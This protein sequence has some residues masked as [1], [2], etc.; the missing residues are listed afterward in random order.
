LIKDGIDQGHGGLKEG[1]FQNT[2]KAF[3][4]VALKKRSDITLVFRVQSQS[5]S[6]VQSL[7]IITSNGPGIFPRPPHP[8]I[9]WIKVRMNMNFLFAWLPRVHEMANQMLSSRFFPPTP[10]PASYPSSDFTV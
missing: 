2:M 1:R 4:L 7:V 8:Q 9:K 5:F 10:A 6:P 3:L